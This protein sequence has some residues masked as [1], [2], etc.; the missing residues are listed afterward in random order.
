VT[1]EEDGCKH[2]GD[3]CQE[4]V[5]TPRQGGLYSAEAVYAGAV[6]TLGGALKVNRFVVRS[7]TVGVAGASGILCYGESLVWKEEVR[8]G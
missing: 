1:Q 6:C 5:R 2:R 3:P 8:R 4:T 7:L